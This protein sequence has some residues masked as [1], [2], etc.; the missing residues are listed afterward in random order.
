M[1]RVLPFWF[2]EIGPT[3]L[4]NK[5]VLIVAHGN[6]I[7]SIIKYLDAYTDEAIM[8]VNVPTAVPLVYELDA[9]LKPIRNYYLMSEEELKQK[10]EEVAK[11]GQAKKWFFYII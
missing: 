1:E 7:R 6:S 4:D 9:N 8:E 5:D 2:D 11:Q 10:M 3:I